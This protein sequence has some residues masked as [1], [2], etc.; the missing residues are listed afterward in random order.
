M[1]G[2]LLL[3]APL[4]G[5]FCLATAS[6]SAAQERN[7]NVAGW[8]M[9]DTGFELADRPAFRVQYHPEASPGPQDSLYLFER[10]VGMIGERK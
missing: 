3:S 10:L 4:A 6:P 2:R 8:T 9:S 7:D 1:G 5:G